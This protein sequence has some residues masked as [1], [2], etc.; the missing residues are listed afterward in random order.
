MN[1]RMSLEALTM[2]IGS[3]FI[4][5]AAVYA[6]LALRHEMSTAA[7]VLSLLCWALLAY[8]LL[9]RYWNRLRPHGHGDK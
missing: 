4:V 1:N 3:V 7:T 2:L 9:P 6:T 8:E 5:A